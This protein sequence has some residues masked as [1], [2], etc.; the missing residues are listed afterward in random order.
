MSSFGPVSWQAL[1]H[2]QQQI[3]Y[4]STTVIYYGLAAPGVST[5]SASWQIR[6]EIL[7]SQGRTTSITFAN[8]TSDYTAIWDNRETYTYS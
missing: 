7:D 6:K 8:G 5:A 4:A 3:H 1:G 2:Y